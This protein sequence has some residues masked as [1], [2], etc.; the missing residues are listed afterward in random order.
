M[1]RS[2]HHN[3]YCNKAHKKI[4]GVCAGLAAYYQQPRW[5][6]RVLAILLLLTFPVAAVAAYLLAA[7]LLPDRYVI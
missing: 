5:L 2:N 6:V 7:C 3:W 4:S 1:N